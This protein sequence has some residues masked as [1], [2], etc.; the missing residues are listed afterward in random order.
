MSCVSKRTGNLPETATPPTQVI[1]WIGVESRAQQTAEQ[2]DFYPYLLE[3]AEGDL[4]PFFSSP[5]KAEEF[6]GSDPE[7]AWRAFSM[8]PVNGKELFQYIDEMPSP[9]IAVL[10]LGTNN[11]QRFTPEDITAAL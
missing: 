11:E 9:V 5:E 6:I 8:T 7:N 4:F 3:Q 1:F 10:N 2:E